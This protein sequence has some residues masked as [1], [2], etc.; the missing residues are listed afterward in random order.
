[1]KWAPW[2]YSLLS[3]E[4]DVAVLDFHQRSD[5]HLETDQA[6]RRLAMM[7]FLQ[8]AMCVMCPRVTELF[9]WKRFDDYR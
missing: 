8:G 1:L 3:L 2:Q 5:A 9:P 6:A 7:R 4:P